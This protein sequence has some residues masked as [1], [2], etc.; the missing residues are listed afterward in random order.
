[1]AKF[2]DLG[3]YETHINRMRNLYRAKRDVLL[4]AIDK[5]NLSKVA[6]IYEED[7][8]LHFIL[9]VNTKYPDAEFCNRARQKGVN[10]KALSEYFFKATPSEHK[11]VINYSSVEKS[12]MKKAVQILADLIRLSPEQ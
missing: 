12:N 11:F 5:S 6:R 8:G 2:I 1:M 4:S 10:I 7:A 9:E 3:Y